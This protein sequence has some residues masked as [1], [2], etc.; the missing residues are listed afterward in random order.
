MPKAKKT[1]SGKYNCKV[2]DH[3][4]Y[5]DGKRKIIFRSITAPT[6]AECER[7]A[8]VFQDEKESLRSTNITI[9]QAVDRFIASR[10][11]VISPNSL[12]GYRSL[13]RNAFNGINDKRVY[14]LRSEHLQLWINDYS[15]THSPKSCRNA[16][17]LLNASIALVRPS[18][19]FSVTLPQRKPPRLYTP[20]DQDIRRLLEYISGTPLEKA[21]LLSAC[22]TLRR[23]EACALTY[24]DIDGCV[25]RVS[26]SLYHEKGA[27]WFVKY[28]KTEESV[29][30]VKYPPAVIDRILAGDR[31][32]DRVVGLL[33]DTVTNQ[34]REALIACGLPLFRFHDLRAYAVSIRHALKIPDV[35]TM[36]DAGYRS[37][38]VMKAIYRRS[39]DDKRQEFSDIVNGH[40]AG[41]LPEKK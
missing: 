6:K 1:K 2:V 40:F 28:P 18:V 14:S 38:T 10:V 26:K 37:D 30:F 3:Y 32:G 23:S 11:N 5:I 20:T 17:A 15:R 12:K 24:D 33:P 13:Q 25:V 7:L 21:V 39:M 8:A 31:R 22:G 41:L 27:G 35:Y 4:E 36:Q 29:R 34:F 16:Y 19:R 9:A